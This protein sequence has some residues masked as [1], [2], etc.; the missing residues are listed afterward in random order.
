MIEWHCSAC[1]AI[2]RTVTVGVLPDGW[3]IRESPMPEAVR[4]L[5][6]G[7]KDNLVGGN[8][9]CVKCATATDLEFRDAVLAEIAAGQELTVATVTTPTEYRAEFDF[10]CPFCT[11]QVHV[12]RD[13]DNEPALIHVSPPCRRFLNLDPVEYMV[14]VNRERAKDAPS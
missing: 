6:E 14:A 10:A 3:G 13:A 12:V 8:P 5:H 4:Q 9:V 7:P 2:V 11:L 1:S